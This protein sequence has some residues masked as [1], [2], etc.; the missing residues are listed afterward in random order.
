MLEIAVATE[1]DLARWRENRREEVDSA[2][3]YR[4]MAA[5]EKRQA[6][7]DI[8]RKLA[9]IEEKHAT[10]WEERLRA[11]GREPGPRAPSLRAR[12]LAWMAGR[13]GASLILPTIAAGE[14]AQRN[15]YLRHP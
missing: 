8:Y 4:A 6:V 9:A 2:A 5:G 10:F 7:A 1:K 3:Q 14:Y 13:F 15:D 11:A 12:V